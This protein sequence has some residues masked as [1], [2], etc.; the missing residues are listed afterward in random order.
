LLQ[1]QTE[2]RKYHRRADTLGDLACQRV[3]LVERADDPAAAVQVDDQ[4]V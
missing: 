4:R 2:I 1:G 3:E